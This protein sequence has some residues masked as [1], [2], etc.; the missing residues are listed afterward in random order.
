MIKISKLTFKLI[1]LGIVAHNFSL[2]AISQQRNVMTSKSAFKCTT[3]VYNLTTDK[4]LPKDICID[5]ILTDHIDMNE[6][7]LGRKWDKKNDLW[8]F[9]VEIR[10]NATNSS[11]STHRAFYVAEESDDHTQY[12]C[13]QED[14]EFK[15]L[16]YNKAIKKWSILLFQNDE[17]KILSPYTGYHYTNYFGIKPKKSTSSSLDF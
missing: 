12:H 14:D 16:I 4:M 1:V 11:M 15:A 6:L 17:Y 9:R 5:V 7:S 3:Y 10:S 2:Q 13:F 8:K